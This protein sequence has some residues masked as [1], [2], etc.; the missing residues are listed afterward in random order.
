MSASELQHS[1]LQNLF[2]EIND[3]TDQP[4]I[5]KSEVDFLEP[6]LVLIEKKVEQ[7]P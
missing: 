1:E 3:A 7:I 4:M 2:R 5:E 6:Y